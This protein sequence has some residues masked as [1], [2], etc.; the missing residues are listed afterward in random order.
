MS[1]REVERGGDG[2]CVCEVADT[3]YTWQCSV[4]LKPGREIST[5]SEE[6]ER[7]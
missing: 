7:T 6:A 1:I 4:V 2:K 5:S 3:S